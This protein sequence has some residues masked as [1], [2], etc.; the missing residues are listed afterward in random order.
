[1]SDQ[2]WNNYNSIHGEVLPNCFLPRQR[3]LKLRHFLNGEE[4]S[5]NTTQYQSKPTKTHANQL[6]FQTNFAVYLW[7]DHTCQIMGIRIIYYYDN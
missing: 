5:N 2:S 1:M 3:P 6:I 4:P 7:A